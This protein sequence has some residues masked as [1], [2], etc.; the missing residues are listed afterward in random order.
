MLSGRSKG[1]RSRSGV[2]PSAST[3]DTSS[4]A[5]QMMTCACGASSIMLMMPDAPHTHVVIMAISAE[6]ETADRQSGLTLS[7]YHG[8][9]GH[10]SL[11]VA[12][13]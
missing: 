6:P 3:V 10:A 11:C 2:L 4:Q 1:E 5:Q 7:R 12:L 9:H 8:M 13:H